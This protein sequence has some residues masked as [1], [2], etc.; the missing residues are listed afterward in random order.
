MKCNKVSYVI[1]K[2]TYLGQYNYTVWRAGR[3]STDL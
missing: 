3:K 1:D 2:P